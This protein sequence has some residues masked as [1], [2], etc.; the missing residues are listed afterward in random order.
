MYCMYVCVC[1][2]VFR[3]WAKLHFLRGGG[4]L[5]SLLQ[6]PPRALLGGIGSPQYRAS[7]DAQVNR[8]AMCASH[9]GCGLV[10]RRPARYC[11]LYCT[12]VRQ[13]LFLEVLPPHIYPKQTVKLTHTSCPQNTL[14]MLPCLGR[15]GT[16]VHS[17]FHCVH[18]LPRLGHQ[19]CPG[20][21]RIFRIFVHFG[22]FFNKNSKNVHFCAYFA[23]FFRIYLHILF[24]FFS[25]LFQD[26]FPLLFSAFF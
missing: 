2:S 4:G 22:T 7:P 21:V 6:W 20:G 3:F 23:S 25:A 10:L 15:G 16:S 24:K 19:L 26:F 17:I 12:V 5:V 9:W 11:T 18:P 14:V 8:L 1:F 13:K